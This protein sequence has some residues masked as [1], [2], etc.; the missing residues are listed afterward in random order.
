MAPWQ[1]VKGWQAD[2]STSDM[3]VEKDD[4]LYY[5]NMKGKQEQLVCIATAAHVSP[6]KEAAKRKAEPGADE[7]K[8][9]KKQ[10][11]T[12]HVKSRAFRPSSLL[13]AIWLH[14]V[15]VCVCVCVC[16]CA[17]ARVCMCV[18]V[19][20]FSAPWFVFRAL[21]T[22]LQPLSLRILL[23]QPIGSQSALLLPAW[24]R[25]TRV[26]LCACTRASRHQLRDSYARALAHP[27]LLSTPGC[28]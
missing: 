27:Q 2:G 11:R 12:R 9:A 7:G 14:C 23:W 17:R 22:C 16:V 21:C 18:C 28:P 24:P 8:N 5:V 25:V 15:I 26:H 6:S 1:A 10:V 3:L 19:C 20:V 13:I 4:Q